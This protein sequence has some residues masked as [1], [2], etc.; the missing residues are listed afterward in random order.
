MRENQ[1]QPRSD[2]VPLARKQSDY[3][4]SIALSCPAGRGSNHE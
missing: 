1:H 2:T 3:H 4:D